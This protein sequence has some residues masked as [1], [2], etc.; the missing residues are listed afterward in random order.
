[1]LSCCVCR[2]ITAT[3]INA[4]EKRHV[5]K[6]NRI[7]C[8]D[9]AMAIRALDNYYR[10]RDDTARSRKVLITCIRKMSMAGRSSVL[11]AG[12]TDRILKEITIASRP[13]KFPPVCEK[14]AIATVIYL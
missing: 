2:V 12:V 5:A 10:R 14:M 9:R 11:S 8:H 7:L 6:A 13:E 4:K 3:N 1:M